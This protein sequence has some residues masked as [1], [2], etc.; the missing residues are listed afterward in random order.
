M[1]IDIFAGKNYF[2]GMGLL[3]NHQEELKDP[4]AYA[5]QLISV[6]NWWLIKIR[7]F[8]TILILVFFFLYRNFADVDFLN[9]RNFLLIMALAVIGNLI[10][11]FSLRRLAKLKEQKDNYQSFFYIATLQLDF[12]LIVISLFTFFSGGF[13]SPVIVL[14]IFY[15]MISTFLIFYKK[16][17]RNTV[18]AIGVI[19]AIFFT[20]ES[21][22]LSSRQL[23]TMLVFNV[24][25][26]SSF[27]ISLF[28]S[29]NLRENE[30]VL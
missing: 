10:F 28:L 12:D 20:N 16:A 23:T 29:R 21:A 3:E 1:I 30:K 18:I 11:S 7:W 2:I 15:I 25:L 9:F 4:Q 8:Y 14:F 5:I 27:F 17:L 26:L 24:I 19:M 6:K 13:E 22:L